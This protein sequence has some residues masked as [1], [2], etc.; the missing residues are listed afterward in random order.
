MY[1]DKSIM[2]SKIILMLSELNCL[3]SCMWR[4]GKGQARWVTFAKA[5]Q[6]RKPEPRVA[7]ARKRTV[8]TLKRRRG[9]SVKLLHQQIS[10]LHSPSCCP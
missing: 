1:L 9:A 3:N 2:M 10:P 5:E 6:Q 7:D 4:Y 8:E